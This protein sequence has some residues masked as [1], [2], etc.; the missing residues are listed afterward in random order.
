M[1]NIYGIDLGTSNCLA[2]ELDEIYDELE[3]NC[4][5]DKEGNI[6][7]PSVIYFAEGGEIIGQKAQKLLPSYPDNTIELVKIR[8]G[9][10]K[11]EIRVQINNKI[12]YYSPQEI[13]AYFLDYFNQIH[14][15]Q[16]EKAVVTVPAYFDQNQRQATLQAGEIADINIVELIDEPAAEILYHIFDYYKKNNHI[17]LKEKK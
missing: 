2:A 8:M 14:E 3:I 9:Q 16:L 12:E 5:R 11:K 1:N 4:L 17:D 15:N 13:S 7:F 6:S 10:I